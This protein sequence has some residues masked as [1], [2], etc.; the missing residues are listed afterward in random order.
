MNLSDVFEKHLLGSPLP[1][2]KILA[3]LAI[4]YP[5]QY[6]LEGTTGLSS[7]YEL[8]A[9][10]I[11]N[12]EA[13]ALTHPLGMYLFFNEPD[14]AI[15]FALRLSSNS[16]CLGLSWGEGFEVEDEIWMGA[17]R[18]EADRLAFLGKPSQLL[19]PMNLFKDHTLP[20]GVGLFTGKKDMTRQVGFDFCELVD[21]R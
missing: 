19:C 14:E 11:S 15:D 6:G 4:R 1:H 17:A 7:I 13:S 20:Q 5:L 16:F 2:P 9:R 21:Y 10:I 18:I 12:A 3:V 8:N